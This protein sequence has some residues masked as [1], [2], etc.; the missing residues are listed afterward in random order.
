MKKKTDTN[1]SW[2]DDFE[3]LKKKIQGKKKSD[4]RKK[5]KYRKNIFGDERY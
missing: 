2:D 5:E 1:F 4:F 3:K